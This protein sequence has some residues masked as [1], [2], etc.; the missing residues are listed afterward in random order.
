MR[1]SEFG[2][3]PPADRA[4]TVAAASWAAAASDR[5]SSV[6]PE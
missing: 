5:V 4:T 3:G 1:P 2:Q 6:E